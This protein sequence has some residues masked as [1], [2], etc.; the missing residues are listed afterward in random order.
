[1]RCKEVTGCTDL[2]LG[3]GVLCRPDLPRLVAAM[4]AGHQRDSLYWP[5][6]LPLILL[7]FDLTAANYDACYVGNPIKQ[8]LAYMRS[9]FPQAGLL[10]ER[11]KRLRDP[12]AIRIELEQ[13][14]LLSVADR[15]V[16]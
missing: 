2:M 7:F 1:M 9:Y 13:A 12:E 6:V 5:D 3:R 14:N 16:A 15:R 4:A 10:F 8:W 11:V